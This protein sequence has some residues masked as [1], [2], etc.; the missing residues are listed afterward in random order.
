[1]ATND[2][3]I[4]RPPSNDVNPENTT[5]PSKVIDVKGQKMIIRQ[6]GREDMPKL[7]ETVYKTITIDKD[8]LPM[9]K[10]FGLEVS[11]F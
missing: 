8:F 2:E 5:Y 11:S 7:L 3:E 4:L 6:V 1:M 10:L 9:K